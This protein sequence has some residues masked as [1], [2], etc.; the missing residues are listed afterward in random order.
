MLVYMR[1]VLFLDVS[2]FVFTT[3]VDASH[4]RLLS[5]GLRFVS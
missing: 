5:Y 4:W 2:L 3:L 1:T